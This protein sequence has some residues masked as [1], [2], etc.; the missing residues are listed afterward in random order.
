MTKSH[1]PFSN[2]CLGRGLNGKVG[3]KLH[4]I[5]LI[6]PVVGGLKCVTVAAKQP[7]VAMKWAL[8]Q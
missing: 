7:D 8:T 5:Y 4:E 6:D 1:Q 2:N 3:E